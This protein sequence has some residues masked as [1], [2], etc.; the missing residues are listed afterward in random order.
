MDLIRVVA[1]RP[2]KGSAT[3]SLV[4]NV[5][6]C[7]HSVVC[8][9]AKL[10]GKLFL[11]PSVIIQKRQSSHIFEDMTTVYVPNGFSSDLRD[12]ECFRQFN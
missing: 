4:L 1:F 7:Q 12:L 10:S 8:L 5:S 2:Q 9:V 6:Q 3:V 11:A